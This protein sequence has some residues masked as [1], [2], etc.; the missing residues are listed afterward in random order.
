MRLRSYETARM[1]ELLES[2]WESG[3]RAAA[4]ILNGAVELLSQRDTY[5]IR[6]LIGSVDLPYGPFWDK[7]DAEKISAELAG[8]S[9]VHKLW[10][11]ASLAEV[12]VTAS[13]CP[14]CDHPW[15][16]HWLGR[17]TGCV[18]KGCACKRTPPKG[19]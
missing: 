17:V 5:A 14:D 10:G 2:E 7:A 12:Q 16:A 19:R 8:P 9:S 1:V 3:E 11:W 18:V 13:H 15:F 4:G 6:S